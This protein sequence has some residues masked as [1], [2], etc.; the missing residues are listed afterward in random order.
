[1]VRGFLDLNE[2]TLYPA[3]S[4]TARVIAEPHDQDGGLMLQLADPSGVLWHQA[5]LTVGKPSSLRRTPLSGIPSD[6]RRGMSVID[7]EN[8]RPSNRHFVGP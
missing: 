7:G 5:R 8:S 1:M 4:G 3:H 6:E 2:G